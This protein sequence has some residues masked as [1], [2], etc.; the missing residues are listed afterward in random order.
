MYFR[1]KKHVFSPFIVFFAGIAIAT[2]LAGCASSGGAASEDTASEDT[3]TET[4]DVGEIIL[5]PG[6]SKTCISTPC[7]VW[8]EMPEGSGTFA[9]MQDNQVKLGDYPAGQKVKI[10]NFWSPHYFN[11]PE[12]DYPKSHLYILGQ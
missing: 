1:L 8:F 7:A 6:A 5:K 12:S 10:G 3:P 9:L 11:I 2:G 4:E